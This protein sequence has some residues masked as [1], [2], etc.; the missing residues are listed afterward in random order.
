MPKVL[1]MRKRLEEIKSAIAALPPELVDGEVAR[2][3][4]DVGEIK[5]W[6]S[7]EDPNVW[8]FSHELYDVEAE[9]DSI[10]DCIDT[11]KRWIRVFIEERLIGNLAP[12]VEASSKG[13]AGTPVYRVPE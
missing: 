4:I 13:L 1:Q 10:E 11:Y 9:G 3:L 12:D 2:A 7:E 6:Q 8:L 5:P